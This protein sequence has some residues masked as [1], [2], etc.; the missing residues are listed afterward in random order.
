[1]TDQI[2]TPAN[3]AEKP[4]TLM[5]ALLAVQAEAP[6]LKL[7]KDA[8]GQV[9]G[10]SSYKYLSLDKLMGEVL[11]L[12]NKNG[13]VWLTRP[14]SKNGEPVLFYR[15]VHGKSYDDSGELGPHC[16]VAGTFPLMLDKKNSQGLGS[17]LT[18]ARRYALTAVLGIVPDDDDDG[19]QASKQ[20]TR[21]ASADRALTEGELTA[22][23]EAIKAKGQDESLL[24]ASAG[25]EDVIHL[26]QAREIRKLLEAL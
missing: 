12:L 5:E 10:N 2:D 8:S 14:G 23:R 9:A 6:S 24:L 7:G 11:P 15:L 4:A 25:V 20:P 17:A 1:M 18:Y 26:S 22:M 13:L 19:A 3:P 16:E 21:I